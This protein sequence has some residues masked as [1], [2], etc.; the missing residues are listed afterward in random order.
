MEKYAKL[1]DSIQYNS[2][3]VCMLIH[4][5]LLYFTPMHEWEG[6]V[7][8]SFL[9]PSLYHEWEEGGGGG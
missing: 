5:S 9:T 2:Q 6:G 3:K 4:H 7:G 1:V 8:K